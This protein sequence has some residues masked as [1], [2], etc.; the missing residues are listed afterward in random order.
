[1]NGWRETKKGM[2]RGALVVL[3][4]ATG[5]GY[6]T[7]I[8]I[9]LSNLKYRMSCQFQTNIDESNGVFEGKTRIGRVKWFLHRQI[10]AWSRDPLPANQNAVLVQERCICRRSSLGYASV[11]ADYR[12]KIYRV[13]S[14]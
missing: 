11:P 2:V 9:E 7:I 12:G 13:R 1:M 6:M 5:L 3:Y 4:D 8:C 14:L 10:A